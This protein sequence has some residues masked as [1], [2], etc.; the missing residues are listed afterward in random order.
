[1]AVLAFAFWEEWGYQVGHASEGQ[2]FS[3]NFARHVIIN[4]ILRVFTLAYLRVIRSNER[5]AR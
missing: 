2:I 1:V 3:H 5:I 4:K